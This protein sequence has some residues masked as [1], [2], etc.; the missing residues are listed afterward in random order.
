MGQVQFIELQLKDN[1]S[2]LV[3]I[4]EKN[5][6]KVSQIGRGSKVLDKVEQSLTDVLSVLNPICD[7]IHGELVK[8][9]NQPDEAVIEFGLKF[10]LSGKVVIAEVNSEASL[11]ISLTWKK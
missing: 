6:D 8:S 4:S 7:S 2:V 11:K 1:K 10:S 3:E 5:T 9:D